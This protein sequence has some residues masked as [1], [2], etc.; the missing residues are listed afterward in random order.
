MQGAARLFDVK[1]DNERIDVFSMKVY[2]WM[3]LKR[4]I[5]KDGYE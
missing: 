1:P 2:A 5:T 3:L 4:L